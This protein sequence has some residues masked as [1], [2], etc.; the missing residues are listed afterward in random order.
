MKG[1]LTK[2]TKIEEIIPL[3]FFIEWFIIK[4]HILYRGGTL[5]I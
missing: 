4:T 5:H 1:A 3:L 2:S